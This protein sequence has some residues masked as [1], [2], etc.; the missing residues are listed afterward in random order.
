MN[1]ETTRL[2]AMG[3]ENIQ[4]G[5]SALSCFVVFTL[6]ILLNNI[7]DFVKMHNDYKTMTVK[8]CVM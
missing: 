6:N 5:R 7:E 3:T 2:V 8:I 4:E 1:M